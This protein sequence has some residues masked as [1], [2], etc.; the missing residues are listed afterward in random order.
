M[1]QF[2][3]HYKNK[4]PYFYVNT[5]RKFYVYPNINI[6]YNNMKTYAAKTRRKKYKTLLRD[7]FFFL[8]FTLGINL[9]RNLWNYDFIY[10]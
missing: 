6:L 7:K 9:Q 5:K 8:W 2:A 1:V 10:I 4:S 3:A